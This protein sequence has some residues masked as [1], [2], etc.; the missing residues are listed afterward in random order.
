MMPL[1][2]LHLC[3]SLFPVGGFAHSEGLEAAVSAGRVSSGAD[4]RKWIDVVLGEGLRCNEGPAVV[5]AWRAAAD[6]RIED[7]GHLDE[8][9]H[10]LR[11]S[12]TAR[13][14]SRAMGARL[15]TTW[16]EIHPEQPLAASRGSRL[17]WPI[18]FGVVCAGAGVEARS[19][20]EAFMYTRLSAT[21]SS[22]MRLMPI[23]QSEAHGLLAS[24]LAEVPAIADDVEARLA[25]GE[26]PGAF[27]PAFD[28]ATMAQQYVGSRLFLS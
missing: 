5:L 28:L 16:R 7:L 19:A 9:M 17:T 11:P 10:A 23:G 18:A 3:D 13:A 8:E 1:A 25:R 26:C 22:A 12:S 6:G 24:A 14:A 2:L 4:L 20:L 27:S 21:I 15:L